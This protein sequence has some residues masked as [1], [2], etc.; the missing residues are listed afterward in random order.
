MNWFFHK[1]YWTGWIAAHHRRRRTLLAGSG[2]RALTFGLIALG[3]TSVYREG[4]EIVLF[5]QALRVKYGAS[6]VLQGVA[7]GALFTAAVGVLTFVVHQKL[8]YKKML[9][10]TGALLGVVLV[11]MVGESAQELQLA[12][13]IPT[14]SLGVSFPGWV[15]T[16]FA[17][18]PTVETVVAQ[19]VAALAVIGSYLVAEQVRVRAPRRRGRAAAVRPERAP[20]GGHEPPAARRA[21]TA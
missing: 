16:W 12:G 14:T 11:V 3:F 9:V 13:W 20:E 17:L 19:A 15:G 2:G 5:L 1:V 7:L 8:P 6:V 21:M 10:L 18:F 4:F